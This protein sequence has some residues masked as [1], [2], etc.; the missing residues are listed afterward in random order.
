MTSSEVLAGP[1]PGA[2]VVKAGNTLSVGLCAADP[3]EGSGK[4]V[5]FISGNDA[6]GKQ[7]GRQVPELGLL[8]GGRPG[9]LDDGGRLQGFPGGPLPQLNLVSLQ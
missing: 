7:Q 8:G 9:G 4:R 5:L 6:D 3:R 2:R 1:L